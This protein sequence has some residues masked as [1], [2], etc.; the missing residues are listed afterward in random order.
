LFAFVAT[1][2]TSLRDDS[3]VACDEIDGF[4]S[5]LRELHLDVLLELFQRLVILL[6][7]IDQVEQCFIF[8]SEDV[9]FF[10]YFI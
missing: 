9:K 5:I 10:T 6:Q 4:R 1:D 8:L 7:L 3:V 2:N